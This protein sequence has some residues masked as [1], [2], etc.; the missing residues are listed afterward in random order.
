MSRD[1]RCRTCGHCWEVHDHHGRKRCYEY[2]DEDYNPVGDCVCD[3]GWIPGDNLEYLEWEY[4]RSILAIEPG[5]KS[6]E[7][8]PPK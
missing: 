1:S 6:N 7:D 8:L 2:L 5:N 3:T 4:D